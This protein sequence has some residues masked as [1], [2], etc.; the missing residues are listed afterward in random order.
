MLSTAEIFYQADSM[1]IKSQ[2]YNERETFEQCGGK[3]L[4]FLW[5]PS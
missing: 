3:T 2:M 5:K 4:F 1:P